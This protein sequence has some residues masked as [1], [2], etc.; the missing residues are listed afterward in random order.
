MLSVKTNITM[1]ESQKDY[2]NSRFQELSRMFDL[3]V[4]NGWEPPL[5]YHSYLQTLCQ[6][7][8]D[9]QAQI[10]ELQCQIDESKMSNVPTS[11]H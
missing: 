7:I 6:K 3:G 1:S 4:E 9:L 10:T 2:I 11:I 8:N 5:I